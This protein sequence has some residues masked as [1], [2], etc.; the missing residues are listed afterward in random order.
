MEETGTDGRGVAD[1]GYQ[2]T[3]AARLHPQDAEAAVL[4]VKGDALDETGEVL[5]FGCSLRPTE[6]RLFH[7]CGSRPG[8]QRHTD[9]PA[10]AAMPEHARRCAVNVRVGYHS[11]KRSDR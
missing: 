1:D 11:A 2:I 7:S 10:I 6:A 3:L 8:I 9:R 5:T 4:V